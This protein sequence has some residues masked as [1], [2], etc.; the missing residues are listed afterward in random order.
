MYHVIDKTLYPVFYVNAIDFEGG[1]DVGPLGAL[2]LPVAWLLLYIQL[3]R[4]VVLGFSPT[5]CTY[6]QKWVQVSMINRYT[7]TRY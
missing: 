7:F 1:M 2:L 3:S 5:T 6:Y 4:F